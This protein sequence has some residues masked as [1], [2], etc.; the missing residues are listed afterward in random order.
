MSLS[1]SSSPMQKSI[2]QRTLILI[3]DQARRRKFTTGF[4][5]SSPIFRAFLSEPLIRNWEGTLKYWGIQRVN[6]NGLALDRLCKEVAV[7]NETR[8]RHWRRGKGEGKGNACLSPGI[9]GRRKKKQRREKNEKTE[10]RAD[11]RTAM[12]EGERGGALLVLRWVI[13]QGASN[14]LCKGTV[15]NY[16]C[17]EEG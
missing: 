2:S 16:G 17:T 14:G 5:S 8:T 6:L 1:N 15:N 13:R 9:E 4:I 12:R 11:R 7:G 3:Q 10:E